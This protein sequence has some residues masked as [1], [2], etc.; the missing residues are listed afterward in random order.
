MTTI[1]TRAAKPNST[2]GGE[3]TGT[4]AEERRVN[5]LRQI[6]AAGGTIAPSA[7]PQ[8]EHGYAFAGLIGGDVDRDLD[9]LARRNYLEARFF[10]RVSLCPK[11]GSHH[12]NVREVCPSCRRAHVVSE[13]LLHHFRCG[14]VGIPSEFSP[15]ADGSYHCPKC[16][17]K[18]HHLGTEYDRLGRA[19]VCRSCGVI[20]ENPPVEAVCLACNARA[21]AENLVSALVFSYVLTSRGANAIRQGSL[22]RGDEEIIS[23]ADAPVYRRKI[24]LEFLD[25]ELK[26]LREFN[27]GF[28][29]LLVNCAT[30]SS[31]RG[32]DSR[33]IWLTRLRQCLREVDQIGQLAD[34]LY[35]VILPHTGRRAADALRQH[36]VGELGP[37]SPLTL[38]TKE[39]TQSLDLAQVVAGLTTRGEPS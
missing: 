30:S 15:A 23:V 3:D 12:L 19:F 18:M 38:S 13:G 17:C 20:S 5:L 32:N 14:Y 28:S 4:A 31:E 21:A 26:R 27:S 37:N 24:I 7:N 29:V 6:A 22:F 16:N 1:E 2:S 36:I 34:S 39:I 25:H 8:A 33:V 10:D 35:L 11:C 9:I